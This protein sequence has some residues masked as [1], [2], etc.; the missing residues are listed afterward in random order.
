MCWFRVGISKPSALCTVR[1]KLF[2]FW[3]PGDCEHRRALGM[4]TAWVLPMLPRDFKLKKFRTIFRPPNRTRG[5]A[6]QCKDT[7]FCEVALWRASDKYPFHNLSPSKR[8]LNHQDTWPKSAA[9]FQSSKSPSVSAKL[10]TMYHRSTSQ[11][12]FVPIRAENAFRFARFGVQKLDRGRK[13]VKIN[14]IM[15]RTETLPIPTVLR[16]LQTTRKAKGEKLRT[17][18]ADLAKPRLA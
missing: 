18:C 16:C 3:S 4:D 7:R 1:T 9:V 13:K 14:E 2:P 11:P 5:K 10:P 8:N 6:S 12:L 17:Y 15:G